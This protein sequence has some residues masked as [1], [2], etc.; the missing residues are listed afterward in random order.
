[1]N[2]QEIKKEEEKDFF[3][4]EEIAKRYKQLPNEIAKLLV[5]SNIGKKVKD[6]LVINKISEERFSDVMYLLCLVLIGFY[7]RDD[8]INYLAE[9]ISADSLSA[10]NAAKEINLQVFIPHKEAIDKLYAL[11]IGD[12]KL[13]AVKSSE[14]IIP[15]KP[16]EIF[17][18]EVKP[19]I[20]PREVNISSTSKVI[21]EKKMTPS[22]TL[23]FGKETEIR[24]TL[25]SSP[26][27]SSDFGSSKKQEKTII[28]A[29][30]SGDG[31]LKPLGFLQKFKNKIISKKETP[32]KLVLNQETEDVKK[33]KI[34]NFSEKSVANETKEEQK[35][36]IKKDKEIDLKKMKF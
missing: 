27:I 12:E 9:D 23:I 13:E 19:R 8:F 35:S 32:N 17:K 20:F 1:M 11:P 2:N 7:H 16:K 3:S 21:E 10:Q 34:V 22:P 6:I 26:I 30:E 24:P 5:D 14:I 31:N 25:E 36:E 18:D 4:D 29:L 15:E 28:S 33:T